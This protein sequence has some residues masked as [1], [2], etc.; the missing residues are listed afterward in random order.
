MTPKVQNRPKGRPR[1]FDVQKAV[2]CALD[3]FLRKGYEGAS[4][5]DLTRAMGIERPSLYAAFGDKE[6]L[7][8]KVLDRYM[9]QT[10][11]YLNSALQEKTARRFVER[12][13]RGALESQTDPHNAPGCLMVQGALSCA[14]ESEPIREELACRR[15]QIEAAI[16]ARLERARK[17]GDRSVTGSPADLA[18]Y[19]ATVM[20]GMSVQV[21]GGASRKELQR[22]VDT[23]LKVF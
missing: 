10:M 3:V 21:A 23:A 18:R 20:H 1:A 15:R 9:D 8:R 2:D 11:V 6:G 5:T 16:R 14:E 22:V 17:E 4:M 19:L 13:L 12:V 7:F